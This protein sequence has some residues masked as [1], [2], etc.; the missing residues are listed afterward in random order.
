VCCGRARSSPAPQAFPPAQPAHAAPHSCCGAC[1]LAL[2]SDAAISAFDEFSST[3]ASVRA[4]RLFPPTARAESVGLRVLEEPSK[5]SGGGAISGDG[6]DSGGGGGGGGGGGSPCRAQVCLLKF[7]SPGSSSP[8]APATESLSGT[9][10]AGCHR[11]YDGAVIYD[12]D[13]QEVPRG[14]HSSSPTV[15][16]AG[17]WRSKRGAFKCK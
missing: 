6:S 7:V 13:V 5:T 4:R 17:R 12:T 8:A 9:V 11:H 1:A 2:F 14:R 15:S 10:R 16:P 3:L